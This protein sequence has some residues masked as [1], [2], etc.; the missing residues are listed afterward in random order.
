MVHDESL[1]MRLAEVRQIF[2][3]G[4]PRLAAYLKD[5]ARES[6]ADGYIKVECAADELANCV[7]EGRQAGL[8]WEE[9]GQ[10]IESTPTAAEHIYGP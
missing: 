4:G 5:A 1:Q 10:L 8:S 2:A 6:I 3:E 7:A 9:I